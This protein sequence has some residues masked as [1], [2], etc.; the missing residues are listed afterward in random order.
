MPCEGVSG[1]PLFFFGSPWQHDIAPVLVDKYVN[2]AT[3][4]NPA[5][6][7]DIPS[8]ERY[9]TDLSGPGS[10]EV[11]HCNPAAAPC[12]AW[13]YPYPENVF[14]H[15]GQ[16]QVN[17]AVAR[18]RGFKNVQAR[19]FWQGVFGWVSSQI[20]CPTNICANGSTYRTAQT[21]VDGTKYLTATYDI[22]WRKDIVAGE[23]AGEFDH[24]DLTGA[25]TV[26]ANTGEITSTLTSSEDRNTGSGGTHFVCNAGVFTNTDNDTGIVLASGDHGGSTVLD[27]LELDLHCGFPLF[28]VDT[29]FDLLGFINQWNEPGNHSTAMPL[30][31]DPNN[32]SCSVI[33]VDAGNTETV[34]AS[35]S[36][37]ATSISWDFFTSDDSDSPGNPPNTWHHYGS[38][39]FSNE[40]TS[41]SVYTDIKNNLLSLW[42]LNDDKLYPWRTDLKVSVAPL[43]SRN[44]R[45]PVGPLGFNSYTVDDLTSPIND[46]NGNVPFTPGWGP[47]YS[48]RPWF[49]PDCYQWT[50]APGTDQSN[51][52]ATGL[53][54]LF[55]GSILGAPKPA[56]YQNFFNFGYIDV[57]G[58]CQIDPES[59][60]KNWD[61]Y[62][63]GWGMNVSTFNVASG[64]LLPLNATQWNNYLEAVNKPIGAWMFYADQGQYVGAGC[65]GLSSSSAGDSAYLVA[66]KSAECL[67]QWDSQNFALPAGDIKFWFDETKV[68]CATNIAGTGAGSTWSLT[69]PVTG[70]APPDDTDFS[71]VWG[72]PVAGGFYD[73]TSY[74]G[75]TLTLGSKMFDLPRN[76]ASKSEVTSGDGTHDS[77]F[78]F[79]KL[80]FPGAPALLGRIGITPDGA[81][82]TMTFASTQPAF[83]MTA[84]THQEL[85]DLWDANMNPLAS[86]VTAT[87]VDDNTFTIANAQ[88][89]AAFVTIHGATA[90]Y[91]ND[92]APKG[93]YAVLEWMSD[94][95]SAAEFG[96]LAGVL[97]CDG[98]QIA[99]PTTNAGGGPV[100]QP[101][102]SFTQTAGCLPFVPCS[103]K[104]VCIS[105]N[106]ET[107]PNG[108]TFDFPAS[109]ACDEQY[110][111]K[112]WS[113][114]QSTMTDIFWQPPHHPCNIKPCA[115]W[116]MDGGDC[117]DDSIEDGVEFGCPGD[118]GFVEGE[119]LPPVYCF[120]H[121]P[122]VEARLTVPCTYGLLR[123]ECPPALPGDI[124]IGWLSPVMNSSGDIALPP[125][126]P[127]ALQDRGEPAGASTTWDFH[128]LLCVQIAAGCRFKYQVPGC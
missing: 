33:S 65:A 79:G 1:K 18:K 105:P 24:A 77:D 95:R 52:A 32:Y 9:T 39:T 120:A 97:N 98:N 111:S 67:E 56:G 48:Q 122:Q 51:S 70:N 8:Y 62:Q 96:R 106:G 40:N 43:V 3:V 11:H 72:G 17:F 102:A 84:S 123:N 5:G 76:W 58:C 112:W 109:F 54:L 78:C 100:T 15:D 91:M 34:V 47:T 88:H 107:F 118:D 101:F 60:S 46:P 128:S 115:Q 57:A 45:G 116:K 121:A 29:A 41:D 87:R 25:R 71:G 61:W 110:G 99:Q 28:R 68:F 44:E 80:R 127:G 26:N 93:D 89:T 19:R 81:G 119:T 92:T 59:G 42:P 85:V 55:D 14:L 6:G 36:R 90:W 69:D 23:E 108:K 53:Q 126:P 124:Q 7:A 21:T 94:F 63:V 82:T 22:H 125:N 49:D 31:T 114:V 74:S 64:C 75:G 35:L 83:G 27:S 20:N 16:G 2:V 104:V 38:I 10:C 117:Q 73:V 66:C 12:A 30:V 86:A 37:T 50:F 113:Y 103:P 13:S 4:P